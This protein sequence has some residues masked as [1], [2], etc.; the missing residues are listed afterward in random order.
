MRLRGKIA[1]VTG[2]ARGMGKEAA[3]LFAREGAKV[4]VVDLHE[5]SVEALAAEIVA[6]GCNAIG[7]AADITS[8]QAVCVMVERTVHE[9]GLPT[10][11]FNNAGADTEHKK[12][13]MTITEEEFDRAVAV[14]FKGPW[15]VMRHVIPKMIEAGGGSVV[16]TASIAN[17]IAGNT[18]GYSAAKA[19]VVSMTRVAAVEFGGDNIRINALSP[20]ATMTPMAMQVRAENEAKGISY[21]SSIVDKMS[22]LGRMADPREMAQMA[23]FL[24]SDESSYATGANFINDGGWTAKRSFFDPRLLVAGDK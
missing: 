13:L 6:Q 14:N 18:V 23:L 15:M 11:L 3:L 8:S 20:G 7:I 4:A 9:F 1:I 2:A 16:N 5:A 19:A 12:S 17:D 24:A 21:D 10:V 22:L